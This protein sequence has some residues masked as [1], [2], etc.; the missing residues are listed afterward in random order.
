MKSK[1]KAILFLITSAFFFSMMSVFV[2]LSG[3][4]PTF[5]KMFFRNL[6]AAVI[7]FIILVKNKTP[8][9]P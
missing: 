5:Q 7:A 8:F 3:D 6:I 1:N 4:L 2:R 9:L